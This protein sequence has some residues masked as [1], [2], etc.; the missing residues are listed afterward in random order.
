MTV[1]GHP[2]D[3]PRLALGAVLVSMT[4]HLG[5]FYTFLAVASTEKAGIDNANPRETQRAVSG[6]LKGRLLATHH[7]QARFV[8]PAQ[9]HP[10]GG[11]TGYTLQSSSSSALCFVAQW[12]CRVWRSNDYVWHEECV[13]A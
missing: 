7:N 1:V 9:H 3:L 11:G 4:L 6:T 2:L 8:S 5:T 13:V 12:S 10:R